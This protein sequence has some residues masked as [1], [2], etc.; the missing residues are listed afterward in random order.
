VPALVIVLCAIVRATAGDIAEAALE[1]E[2]VSKTE[3]ELAMIVVVGKGSHFVAVII[4][5]LV[6]FALVSLLIVIA[7]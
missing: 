5:V 3:L 2:L 1:T 4:S 7:V 6:D